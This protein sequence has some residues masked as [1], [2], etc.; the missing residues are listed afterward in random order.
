[1][2]R[3]WGFNRLGLKAYSMKYEKLA[4]RERKFNF[5]LNI[6]LWASYLKKGYKLFLGV[7]AFSGW[8]NK[9]VWHGLAKKTGFNLDDH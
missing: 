9:G 6:Y 1:M 3:S 8:A 5:L 4:S 7:R 2:F